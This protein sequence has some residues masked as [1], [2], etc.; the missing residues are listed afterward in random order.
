MIAT[1]SDV[2]T[3][4]V[5]SEAFLA[6]IKFL[7]VGAIALWVGGLIG[8]PWLMAQRDGIRRRGGRNALH[9]LHAMA[10][11]P[12]ISGWFRPPRWWRS[13]RGRR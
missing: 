12:C 13:S 1:L 3:G 9:R 8:L 5:T 7:H 10:R 4:A 6:A 2:I 11:G